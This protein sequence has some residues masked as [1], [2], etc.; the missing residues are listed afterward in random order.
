[1]ATGGD[2]INAFAS[3]AAFGGGF[4]HFGF[5]KA[6]ISQ[7]TKRRVSR[8]YGNRSSGLGFEFLGNFKRIS[9]IAEYPH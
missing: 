5:E 6:F 8:T 9:F 3:T 2:G 4:A 7:S 1:M